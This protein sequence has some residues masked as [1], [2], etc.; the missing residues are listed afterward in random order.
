[1]IRQIDTPMRL[2]EGPAN[3]FVAGFFGSS[4]MNFFRGMLSRDASHLLQDGTSVVQGNLGAARLHCFDA[5]SGSRI[6]AAAADSNLN[7]LR[8]DP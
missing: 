1:M 6:V 4:A 8:S 5:G 2:Y 3:L 7:T